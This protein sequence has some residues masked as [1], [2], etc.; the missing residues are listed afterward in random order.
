MQVTDWRWESVVYP[1]L[2]FFMEIKN[3]DSFFRLFYLRKFGNVE[4]TRELLVQDS[5]VPQ[6]L[7]HLLKESLRY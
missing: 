2:H 5:D 6:E 3:F 4:V 7:A 1:L